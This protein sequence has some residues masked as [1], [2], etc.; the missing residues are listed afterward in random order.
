MSHTAGRADAAPSGQRGTKDGVQ[1]GTWRASRS[2]MFATECARG[3]GDARRGTRDDPFDARA[4]A[5]P[6]LIAGAAQ[7]RQAL[8][9]TRPD[10]CVHVLVSQAASPSPSGK[11]G[12][13]P[14]TRRAATP[15]VV[16]HTSCSAGHPSSA[17]RRV[18]TAP[19]IRGWDA[20]GLSAG[21]GRARPLRPARWLCRHGAG[22]NDSC[23]N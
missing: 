11:A 19:T 6:R 18:A 22:M 13:L 3:R 23:P 2:L 4:S 7:H 9:S 21:L 14:G 20:A 5:A 12:P 16:P 1:G 10:M 17:A 8:W 15:G